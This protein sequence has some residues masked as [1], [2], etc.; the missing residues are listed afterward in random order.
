MKCD[1][2][3]ICDIN[4]INRKTFIECSPKVCSFGELCTNNKIQKRRPVPL[5]VF[6]TNCKGF[7]IKTKK[8]IKKGSFIIE[9]IGEIISK[10]DFEKRLNSIYSKEIHDYCM[11]FEKGNVIDS[12]RE[13][14]LSRFINHSCNPN[15][16]IQKWMVNGLSRM[17]LFAKEYIGAGCELTFDYKFFRYNSNESKNCHCGSLNCC[18]IIGRRALA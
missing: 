9:Y 3:K 14:N 11:Q 18:G 12:Y 5:Q 2:K 16:E 4:C 13:G 7:G 17:A 15:C 10:K 1:C 8:N 6:E